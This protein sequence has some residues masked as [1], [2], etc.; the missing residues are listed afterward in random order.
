[1]LAGTG[2]ASTAASPSPA[3]LDGLRER[4]ESFHAT[5]IVSAAC[6][7]VTPG[8]AGMPWVARP[9]PASA[10]RPSTWPW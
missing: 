2:S 10:S 4:L 8:E 1:M 9:E 6:A 3:A 7:A 5:T